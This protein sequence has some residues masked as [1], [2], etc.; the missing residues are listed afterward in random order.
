MVLLVGV[1]VVVVVVVVVWWWFGDGGGVGRQTFGV[2]TTGDRQ[3]IQGVCITVILKGI[4]GYHCSRI[5]KVT[6]Q[7]NPIN[8]RLFGLMSPMLNYISTSQTASE[9]P[10]CP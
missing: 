9:L 3:L 4:T 1:V 6:C 5:S 2:K 7:S 10:G 8:A